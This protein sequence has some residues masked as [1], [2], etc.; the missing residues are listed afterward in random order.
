[1]PRPLPQWSP[2]EDAILLGSGTL[3]E[4]STALGRTIPACKTRRRFLRAIDAK[5]YE[6]GLQ[7]FTAFLDALKA[8]ERPP[9]SHDIPE[10]RAIVSVPGFQ[11]SGC[12]TS[13]GWE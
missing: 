7:A 8:A 1:M 9:V 3:A 5:D 12:S 10:G 4:I 13:A 2:E 6:Y 11:G